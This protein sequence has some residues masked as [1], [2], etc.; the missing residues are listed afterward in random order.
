MI[1]PGKALQ[2]SVG[3]IGYFYIYGS[4]QNLISAPLTVM[5]PL[6]LSRSVRFLISVSASC[7]SIPKSSAI[8]AAAV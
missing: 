2:L 1:I 3:S 4:R 6:Y 5:I 7:S 8:S